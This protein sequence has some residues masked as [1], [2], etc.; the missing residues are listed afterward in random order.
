MRNTRTTRALGALTLG[1]ALTVTACGS[2]DTDTA[3]QVST[4]EHNDAD[5]AFA[6]DMLQHHAQALSMVDLTLDRPLD[7]EV[8]QLAEQIRDAQAPEIETFTDWLTDWDEEIP[9]T[10][11]DHSNAGHDMGEMS[12]SMEG[13]DSDMPGM[14][15]ADD[16]THL[17]DAPDAEFQTAWLE[18]M[19]EHHEGAVQMARSETE[20]G[21]YKPAIDL[22]EDIIT[23]Q[24]AEIETMKGLLG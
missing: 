20:D 2:D 24:S 1:L 18:M 19:T 6:T 21:Q 16:M 8:Q 5:V 4:T 14:M 9:E 23:S 12:D 15:S 3:P 10:M 22:A 17:E 13:M 11:R 7:P